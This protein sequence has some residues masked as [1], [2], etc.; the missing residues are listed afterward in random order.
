[1]WFNFIL[2]RQEQGFGC[3]KDIECSEQLLNFFTKSVPRVIRKGNR[4][5][6]L[7]FSTEII[8]GISIYF[9]SMNSLEQSKIDYFSFL[10]SS[11]K[12]EIHQSYFTCIANNV[13]GGSE[14]PRIHN[15]NPT[16]IKQRKLIKSV[17]SKSKQSP[18]KQHS[19]NKISTQI[20][21]KSQ[22][23]VS[24]KDLWRIIAECQK[25]VQ[26]N[27]IKSPLRSPLQSPL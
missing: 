15:G 4:I 2:N 8:I 22:Y 13:R 19:L 23:V 26:G 11:E 6:I 20:V 9:S 16:D 7:I 14:P 27:L 18:F 24:N 21:Q 10:S 17:L 25:P 5:F 3:V 12:V 1:M